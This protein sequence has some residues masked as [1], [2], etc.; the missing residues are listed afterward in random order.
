MRPSWR[1][2]SASR[3]GCNTRATQGT[4][5]DPKGPASIHRAR[6]AIDAQGNVMAY[7]FTSKG[8]SRI[9]VNTNGSKLR[10]TRWP[11]RRSASR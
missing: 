10:S 9:D 3:C 6:A 5:W 7:E 8:F 11:A 1:R 4:G 2:R